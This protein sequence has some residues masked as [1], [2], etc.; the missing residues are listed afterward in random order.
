MSPTNLSRRAILA[1]AASVP[2]L[3]SPAAFASAPV[4]VDPIYAA[5]AAHRTANFEYHDDENIVDEDHPQYDKEM[6]RLSDATKAAAFNLC[7]V[8]PTT[9]AGAIALLNYYAEVTVSHGA[10]GEDWPMEREDK[11]DGIEKP[12]DYFLT[13]NVARALG[14][15]SAGAEAVRS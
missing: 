5:I 1:G 13:R 9:I 12:F 2:A 4:A 10:T 3:A 6:W 7:D 11:Q 15:I 8:Q 14:N